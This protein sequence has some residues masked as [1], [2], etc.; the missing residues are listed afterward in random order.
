VDIITWNDYL[1]RLKLFFRWFQNK[2]IREI[3][4]QKVKAD[5]LVRACEKELGRRVYR[6]SVVSDGF[7]LPSN[8]PLM[9]VS[10]GV[11]LQCLNPSQPCD[12]C[13]ADH[14]I[15]NQTDNSPPW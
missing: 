15:T 7:H 2:K 10:R 13:K 9:I 12:V 1:W 6:L 8:E 14:F 11:L 3:S 4:G 5:D